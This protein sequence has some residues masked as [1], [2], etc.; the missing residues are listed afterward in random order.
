V[1]E[2]TESLTPIASLISTLTFFYAFI[3]NPN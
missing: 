3:V 1:R 2:A